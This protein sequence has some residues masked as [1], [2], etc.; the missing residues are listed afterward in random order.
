MKTK[1]NKP[2]FGIFFG[3]DGGDVFFAPDENVLGRDLSLFES[4]AVLEDIEPAR[5]IAP[6]DGR[7]GLVGFFEGGGAGFG[8]VGLAGGAAGFPAV[9]GFGA[10]LI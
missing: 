8:F 5:S 1:I 2:S 7:G 4:E 9:F 3:F 6:S 10:V